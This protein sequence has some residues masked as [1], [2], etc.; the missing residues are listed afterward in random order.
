MPML[1]CGDAVRGIAITRVSIALA[2]SIANGTQRPVY[3][4]SYTKSALFQELRNHARMRNYDY[5]IMRI[6]S[7]FATISFVT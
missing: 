4:I 2:S 7:Y 3:E 1:L 6:S 5:K